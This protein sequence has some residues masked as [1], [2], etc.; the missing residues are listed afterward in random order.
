MTGAQLTAAIRF[1]LSCGNIKI[2]GHQRIDGTD[3][4]KIVMPGQ[5]RSFTPNA[6]DFAFVGGL[7]VNSSTYLPVRVVY[8]YGDPSAPDKRVIDFQ[9]LAPTKANL[10][11]LVVP[12]PA[13]FKRVYPK[14]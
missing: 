8:S 7:W 9:W 10:A 14:S 13:G 2:A 5:K 4:I 3:T 1:M 11:K 12:I 6:N